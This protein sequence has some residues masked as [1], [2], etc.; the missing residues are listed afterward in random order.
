MVTDEKS[1][2]VQIIHSITYFII[3]A[4]TT[5]DDIEGQGIGFCGNFVGGQLTTMVQVTDATFN[6][7]KVNVPSLIAIKEALYACML[8]NQTLLLHTS[9]M[10]EET[11]PTLFPLPG[12]WIENLMKNR[13]S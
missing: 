6:N 10:N 4:G 8:T 1:N 11:V 5:D 3:L 9:F 7:I 2:K 12:V 13:S